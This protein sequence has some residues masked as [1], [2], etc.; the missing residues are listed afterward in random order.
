MIKDKPLL[1]FDILNKH[2][3]V[4]TPKVS[5]GSYSDLISKVIKTDS[6]VYKF[7][8]LGVTVI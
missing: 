5:L 6:D 2:C 4:V 8:A 7:G 3:A 1:L